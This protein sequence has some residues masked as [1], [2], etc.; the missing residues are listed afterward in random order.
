M[1]IY[2]TSSCLPAEN[3][4]DCSYVF[5]VRVSP[6][7]MAHL[8]TLRYGSESASVPGACVML[9]ASFNVFSL[10]HDDIPIAMRLLRELHFVYP[11]SS[12]A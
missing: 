2:Y 7:E 10:C 4:V 6:P 5:T 12:C 1:Y 11:P 8:V 3:V 9:Q